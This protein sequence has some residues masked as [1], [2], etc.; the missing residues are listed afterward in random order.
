MC[1]CVC[2]GVSVWVVAVA[3][4]VG[5]AGDVVGGVAGGG[6]IVEVY[7]LLQCLLLLWLL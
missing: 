7:V 1:L 3:V 2:L 4:V 6:F 5:G